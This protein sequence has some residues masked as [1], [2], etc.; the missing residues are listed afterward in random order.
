MWIVAWDRYAIAAQ[1]VD[2]QMEFKH[3]LLHKE[4]VIT[5]ACSASAGGRS[6]LLGVLCDE[7]ARSALSFFCDTFLF[8]VL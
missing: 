3:S 5:V 2:H 7:L 6:E 8:S 1:V 4:V